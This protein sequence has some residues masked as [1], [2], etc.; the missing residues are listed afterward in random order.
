[1]QITQITKLFRKKIIKPIHGF[2]LS[3]GGG[4]GQH[5]KIDVPEICP[6]N[7]HAAD[8]KAYWV[9]YKAER[10]AVGVLG[11]LLIREAES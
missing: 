7:L 5:N 9:A 3:L 1:M 8:S 4:N 6:T 11:S 10:L 2:Q